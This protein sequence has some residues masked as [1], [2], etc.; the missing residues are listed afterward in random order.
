MSGCIS[1]VMLDT[2][3][4]IILYIRMLGGNDMVM[5]SI[6]SFT[7]LVNMILFIPSVAI[8]ARIGLK[9]SVRIACFTGTAG[10]LLMALAPYFGKYQC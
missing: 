4:I 2:S 1:E 5:M 9:P 7:G 10:Y 3:A 6:N 8:I